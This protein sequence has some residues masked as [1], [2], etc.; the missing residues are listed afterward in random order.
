MG[1]IMFLV[2]SS[3]LLVIEHCFP[4]PLHIIVVV[5]TNKYIGFC[6]GC[7]WAES[8]AL[9]GNPEIRDK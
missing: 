5:E 6:H 2:Q 9:V 1:F 7:P 8:S 3:N 4:N